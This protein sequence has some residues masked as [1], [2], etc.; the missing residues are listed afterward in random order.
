MLPK[1]NR[2]PKKDFKTVLKKG[3]T[4]HSDY[5][6]MLLLRNTEAKMPQLGIIA[7]L[8]VGKAVKRNLVKRRMKETFKKILPN[9]TPSSQIII[10]CKPAITTIPFKQLQKE[11]LSAF[12]KGNL[13]K[14]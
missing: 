13:Y 12:K 6:V 7:S 2:L 10:I 4:M 1:K 14:K 5:F 3:K 8:K 11:L 9:I